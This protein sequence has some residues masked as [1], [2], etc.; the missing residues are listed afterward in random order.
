MEYFKFFNEA[1]KVSEEIKD[2]LK[3]L[4]PRPIGLDYINYETAL[5]PRDQR[6]HIHVYRD[7]LLKF[8][9]QNSH[10]K[11]VRYLREC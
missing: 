5:V 9:S 7:E 6:S 3:A 11:I 2:N 4:P 10:L 8:A 1:N